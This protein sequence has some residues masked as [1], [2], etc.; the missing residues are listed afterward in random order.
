MISFFYVVIIIYIQYNIISEFLGGW[1]VYNFTLICE[2]KEALSDRHS[3][4]INQ[5]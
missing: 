5:K 1:Y 3:T 4:R 2:D